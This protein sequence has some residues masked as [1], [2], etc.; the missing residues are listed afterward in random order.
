MS[1]F[2]TCHDENDM[3]SSES[4]IS[5]EALRRLAVTDINIIEVKWLNSDWDYGRGQG[6]ICIAYEYRKV[7]PDG[8][9]WAKAVTMFYESGLNEAFKRLVSIVEETRKNIRKHPVYG[10]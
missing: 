8:K 2:G 4:Y 5:T 3:N 7:M 6:W 9:H 1:D 10:E